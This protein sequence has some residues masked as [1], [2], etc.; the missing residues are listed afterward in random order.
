MGRFRRRDRGRAAGAAGEIPAGG[1]RGARRASP[2]P[3][4][5]G[6]SSTSADGGDRME[7]KRGRQRR[8]DM[9]PLEGLRNA[10][11]AYV[12]AMLDEL[13]ERVYDQ[14][15]PLPQAALDYV[16]GPHAAV[17]RPA[18]AAPGLGRDELDR[19]ARATARGR[20]IS[21]GSWPA[22]RSGRSGSAPPAANPAGALVALCRRVRDE[23]T[24]PYL[25]EVADIDEAR[26]D[27]G[28]TVRRSPDAP[29][30]ALD[31]SLGPHRAAEL[32]GG[33][34]LRVDGQATACAVIAGLAR[35]DRAFRARPPVLDAPAGS[36]YFGATEG[37]GRRRAATIPQQ[38][39]GAEC[40]QR[41]R[42][43]SAR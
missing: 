37:V 14:V 7:T 15:L 25:R 39:K 23:V 34:R 9:T 32:R 20:R 16:A 12:A 24:L 21:S 5:R 41:S 19:P 30:L 43:R 38:R 27:D 26:L 28:S 11:V 13:R 22:G 36:N 4:A 3:W 2:R 17:G 10:D 1:R 18:D 29:L 8:Y 6:A 33:V 35:P 42:S 40:P 31:L